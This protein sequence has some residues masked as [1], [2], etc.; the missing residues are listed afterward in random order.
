MDLQLKGKRAFISGSTQGI[1]FAIAQQLLQEGAEVIINGR[2]ENKTRLA[3]ERLR[4]Q[5]PDAVVF[6]C[7]ADFSNRSEVMQLLDE[8]NNIDILI[9]NVG[10]FGVEN[11]YE[12]SDETWYDYLE[13]N[14]MSSMRLSRKLLPAM[15]RNNWGR[16]IFISS[17]SGVNVPENMIHYGTTKAAMNALSNGL[18]KLTKG[19]GVTVN[20]ILGGPTYSDG[21]A[22]VVEQIADAQQID[23][24]SV[25]QAIILQSNP[26]IL[27]QRFLDPAE[28]AS[29]AVYLASPLSVAT[30]GAALRAD[31]G[32]LKV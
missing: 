24:E 11:F 15:I 3:C 17:E 31:S 8:L 25:K 19:A 30:N 32:V 27:L 22:A 16:I 28:I 18:S 7:P 2:N 12:I 29:L 5:F 14:L 1:G 13:I 6:P 9:N 26:H 20:T 23:A 21:V 10:I 4:E